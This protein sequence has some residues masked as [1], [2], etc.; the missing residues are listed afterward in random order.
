LES[1][2]AI[3]YLLVNDTAVSAV[4]GGRVYSFTMPQEKDMPAIVLTIIGNQPHDTKDG[5][6]QVDKV[7]MQITA[8]GRTQN[9]CID[10]SRKIRNAID[11]AAYSTSA[12]VRIEG[13]RFESQTSLYEFERNTPMVANDYVLRVIEGIEDVNPDF[14]FVGRYPNDEA[15]IADG[16]VTGDLYVLTIGNDYAMPGLL[17]RIGFSGTDYF[18]SDVDAILGGKVAGDHYYLSLD[19]LAAMVGGVVKRVGLLGAANYDSDAEAIG[20]GLAAG[21]LYY[22][23]SNNVYGVP[24]ALIKIIEP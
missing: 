4:V 24:E 3:R 11:H 6:S 20:A 2:K 19:N 23:S 16:N 8:V 12:G 17:K 15:A 7:R 5:G 18:A 14:A 9:Q 13:I 10:L 22:L 21:D 1:L